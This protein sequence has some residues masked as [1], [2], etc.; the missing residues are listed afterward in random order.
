LLIL[1]ENQ[2][3]SVAD[4]AGAVLLTRATW[5]IALPPIVCS[6]GSRNRTCTSIILMAVGRSPKPIS[7]S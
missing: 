7:S 1:Q 3:W 5:P 6:T 4:A 2:P